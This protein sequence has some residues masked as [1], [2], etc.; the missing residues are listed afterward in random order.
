M[1]TAFHCCVFMIC[2]TVGGSTGAGENTAMRQTP[3]DDRS[4]ILDHIHSIFEAYL[5]KDREALRRTH[6]DD[7]TGFLGPSTGIER[8]LEDYMRG[9]ERSLQ[10]LHGTAYRLIDTE[11]RLYDD[12]AVVFYIAR[13][14]HKDNDD[15]EHSLPLRSVDIY[16][17]QNG[18]WIQAGSH[19]TPIPAGGTRGEAVPAVRPRAL[20]PEER[21]NLLAAREA[22]WRAW[23]AND[24]PHLRRTLPEELIAIDAG[25]EEW[26]NRVKAL[27]GSAEFVA[28]GSRLVRLEFPRTEILA[29]GDVVILFTTYRF[30][31]ET[32]GTR[33][34]SS[35]RGTEVFVRRD[36]RWVNSG[37]HLD[38]G[39]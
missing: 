4:L 29:Y 33:S 15:N 11:I 32:Q 31:V 35:G 6:A 1:R 39:R 38:S 18:E 25:V 22:L 7:W 17:R 37:W 21:T 5:A 14:D 8:G 26:S 19:I 12:T 2:M 24:E 34:I 10:N 30:E 16:R 3:S 23:F 20:S 36:G 27:R 13:Y 9:A 28:A